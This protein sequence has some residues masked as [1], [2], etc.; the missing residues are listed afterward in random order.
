MAKTVHRP[1]YH[2][3]AA[4]LKE[5]RLK[6][7]LTQGVL[8]QRLSRTQVDVSNVENAVRRLDILEL[9]DYCQALEVSLER[10]VAR[11]ERGL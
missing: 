8:A 3:L 5:A 10:L 1:E 2:S 11:W 7:D 4:L 6:A 9:R